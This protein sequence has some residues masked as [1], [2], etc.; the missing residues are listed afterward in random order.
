MGDRPRDRG[1]WFLGESWDKAQKVGFW[2]AVRLEFVDG[3]C[4][5]RIH[6]PEL[7]GVQKVAAAGQLWAGQ[8]V[9]WSASRAYA[10]EFADLPE[11]S[12]VGRSV[13]ICEKVPPLLPLGKVVEDWRD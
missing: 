1:V 7:S 6:G 9:D 11:L 2:Q 10:D 4:T 5:G 12:L 3:R 8:E 13:I